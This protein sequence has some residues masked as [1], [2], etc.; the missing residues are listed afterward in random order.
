[1]ESSLGEIKSRELNNKFKEIIIAQSQNILDIDK[2]IEDL[3]LKLW[4]SEENHHYQVYLILKEILKYRL[5]QNKAYQRKMLASERNMPYNYDQIRYFFMF[6]F[7]SDKTR[8]KIEEGKLKASTYLSIIRRDAQYR[9]PAIQDKLLDE[10][11]N[12]KLT[13]EEISTSTSYTILRKINS[14]KPMKEADKIALRTIYG[15]NSLNKHL[16]RNFGAVMDSLHIK[17]VLL[18]INK[19]EE[20]IKK[21][22]AEAGVI[23]LDED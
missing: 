15:I 17:K 21:I 13:I 19:L 23:N 5:M 3:K 20:T 4:E 16:I 6:E 11:A 1:M 10:L 22:K 7:M 2:K 8:L 9:Q 18:N 12:E 14:I